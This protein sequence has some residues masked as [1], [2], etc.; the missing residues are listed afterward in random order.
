MYV[1]LDF[2]VDSGLKPYLVEVNVGLP[3]G[4]QEYD[5][6]YQVHFGKSSNIFERIEALSRRISGMSF[7]DYLHRLPFIESLKPFKLWMD[8]QGPF[9]RS[10]HPGLRL[11][12]KW[13]QYTVLRSVVPM[14]ET[15]VF[16]P[17]KGTEALEFLERKRRV[18]LKRRLGRGGRGFMFISN[19]T[20][21]TGLAASAPSPYGTLL[22]EYIASKIGPYTLSLRAVAFAGEFVCMYANLAKR[23]YSNHGI[24]AYVAEADSFRLS[25][26]K[27][28]TVHFNQRSWE[29]TIW[30]GD[31]EPAYLKH[32][33]YEDE[34]ARAALLLPSSLLAEI[35]ALSIRVERLYE[36]LD[37][38]KL[39]EAWFEKAVSP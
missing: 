37:L 33:L 11:E 27:F 7:R 26:E 28:E 20:E 2:L 38:A 35:K 18:V 22:Q 12:D 3:G 19:P 24:L 13:V 30:F 9:P 1:G 25:A 16:N 15:M 10:S 36:D 34:V 14:P 17:Q 29:S 39:P 31:N 23:A 8:G 21:L 4:A 5:L 6:T 32:N